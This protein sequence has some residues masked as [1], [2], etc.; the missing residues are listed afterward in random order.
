MKNK[1]IQNKINEYLEAYTSLWPF[2]G[3][4][5]AIKNGEIIFNKAYGYANI[6]HNVKNTTETKHRIW[7]ITKQFTAAAIL[8]LEEKGL[9]KVE[10]SLK[11]HFPEWA[12]FNDKI[13]IHHLLTHTSGI[14]NYSNE[15]GAHKGY[16]RIHHE[17]SDLIKKVMNKPL[18]FEPGTQWNYSNTGY[19]LLGLLIEKLSEKTY[20]EFLMSNIFEPLGMFNTGIDDEKEIVKNKATGYYLNKNELIHC[21]YVN[22]RLSFSAGSM[23]ST[24][25]DLLIWNQALNSD[26]LLSK[27]S[28]NKMN[29]AY[30]NDYGY[31][32]SVNMNGNRKNVNHNGGCEGFLAELHRYVDDDFAVVVLSNYGFSA[33]WKLCDVIASIAFEEKYD[34]PSKPK[35]F[36]LSDLILESYLGIYDENCDCKL[37]LKKEDKEIFLAVDDDYIW[38]VYPISENVLHHGWIDESYDIT[39]DDEGQLYLWGVKKK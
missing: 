2:S 9:L 21:D 8:I 20:S 34:M 28:V 24:A 4:I 15:P 16:Y 23:Y 27:E 37:E 29:I 17:K 12:D 5:A 32:V 25:E 36:P 10:D 1:E 31:G 26:Q 30:K 6:E 7:S 38:P 22:M 33:V 13:T 18:D 39:K 35:A 19:Y 14:F 3:S 11:K